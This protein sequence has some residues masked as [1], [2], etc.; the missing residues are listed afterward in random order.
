ML[1]IRQVLQAVIL[2]VWIAILALL[3]MAVVVS[4]FVVGPRFPGRG[5]TPIFGA[6]LPWFSRGHSVQLREYH[7]MCVRE[8]RSLV[9]SAYMRAFMASWPPLV[10]V[11]V[12]LSILAVTL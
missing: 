5:A 1:V 12:A 2:P 10:L 8:K 9:W 7:E 4:Y 11:A 3:V 6:A